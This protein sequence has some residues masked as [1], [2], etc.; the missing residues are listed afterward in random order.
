MDVVISGSSGL[1]GTALAAALSEAGHRPIRLV[2]RDPVAGADEIRWDVE[3]GTIDAASL[4]GVDAVVHLAGAGIGDKRWNAA[5][6][7]L[8][9]ESRT[10]GTA[11]LADALAGLDSKPAIF[12]SG[13]AIGFYGPRGDEIITEETPAGETFLADVCVQWEAAAQAAIDAGV[14]TAFLRTG[15]VQTPKGGALSKQL[16]LFKFGL[17]GRFGS[18]RQFQSWITLDDE[19]GA[20][21]HLLNAGVTG[22]V[23]L[24]APAPVTNAEFAKTL[25]KVLKRPAV[26]PV[27]AFGPRLLLGREMADALLFESQRILPSVLEA[28][29]YE[30]RH[31]TLES[32]LRAV[33]DQ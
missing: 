27:P 17:G 14:P 6:K 16:P 26:F 9:L 12:L 28:S 19:V 10:K 8:V 5:Y 2:R 31:P 15:I 4:D 20:I 29:G 3:A 18:G 11:L 24:T 25:G 33:L 30:F 21:I 23:N 1:I 22:P 7:Q 32:G 13:S